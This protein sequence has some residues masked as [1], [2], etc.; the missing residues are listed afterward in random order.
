MGQEQEPITEGSADIDRLV[1][2]LQEIVTAI[3]RA[4]SVGLDLSVPPSLYLACQ[5]IIELQGDSPSPD[6]GDRPSKSRRKGAQSD[7]VPSANAHRP[8]TSR[9]L[10]AVPLRRLVL[11]VINP[12]EEF[13]IVDIAERLEELGAPWPANKISNALG[14][15]VS[16]K[17]LTRK[18]RGVYNWP[19]VG[20]SPSIDEEAPAQ[21]VTYTDHTADVW[22]EDE[23]I[24]IDQEPP[25]QAM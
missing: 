5:A 13:T 24:H 25:R 16:Q 17:R 15:W 23:P 3:D 7:V 9:S 2:A 10:Q 4:R 1:S 19:L 11:Q 22:R 8:A 6:P 14:Y 18:Q 12:G 20:D 21:P